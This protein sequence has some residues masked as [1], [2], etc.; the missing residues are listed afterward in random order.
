WGTGRPPH[1]P[2]AL[3][4]AAATQGSGAQSWARKRL[5]RLHGRRQFCRRQWQVDVVEIERIGD[6]IG[7]AHG[8][9]HAIALTDALGAQ[10]RERRWRLHMQNEWGGYF[11]GGGDEII[12]K[13][14]G[15]E[16]AVRGVGIFLVQGSTERVGEAASY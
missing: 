9:A 5:G 7:N 3:Q 11:H 2:G 6:G 15:K 12:G 4:G 8:R 13:R 1:L 10:R 14:A 16:A